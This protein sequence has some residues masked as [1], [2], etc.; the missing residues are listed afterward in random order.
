MEPRGE[1]LVQVQCHVT[2]QLHVHSSRLHCTKAC[3]ADMRKIIDFQFAITF[4]LFGI[5]RQMTPHWKALNAK[6]M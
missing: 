3:R 5:V 6:N 4:L 2:L 1:L